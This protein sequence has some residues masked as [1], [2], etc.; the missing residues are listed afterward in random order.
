[1]VPPRH[2]R[3]TTLL[4][5]IVVVSVI[6]ILI[7]IILPAVQHSRA[8]ARKTQCLN[9]VRQ[10]AVA[11]HTHTNAIGHFPTDGWGFAWLGFSDRG[12]GIDQ[13]GGWIFNILPYCEQQAVHDM[14]PKSTDVPP[15]PATVSAFV[16][17]SLPLFQCPERREPRNFPADQQVA[18]Y[19]SVT[20]TSCSKS[21][22]AINGGNV[23]LQSISGPANHNSA[24]VSAYPWPDTSA[25]NGISF[26]RSLVRLSDVTDGTSNVLLG[27]EKW[28]ESANAA[29]SGDNQPV[30]VGDCLDIRRWGNIPPAQDKH[31]TGFETGFGSAH[32]GT[33]NFSL[34]DSST[35]SI[36]YFIDPRV[37]VR[38]C[39]RND[40]QPVPSDDSW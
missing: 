1:M 3:A 7:A 31:S 24:T 20:I 39:A 33:A 12:F 2:T 34:C 8:V 38:L 19:G 11:V 30:F 14:A 32:L 5:L 21:D 10:H 4:E 27:G 22:Y 9:Q 23:F 37:F 28:I 26:C 25:L 40:G 13:P 35:R 18:Y 36:P 15:S 16:T 29:T 6:A 17:H